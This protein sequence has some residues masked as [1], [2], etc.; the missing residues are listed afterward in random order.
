ME[1]IFS[2]LFLLGFWLYYKCVEESAIDYCNKYEVDWG[3]VNEDRTKN[4][5]SNSQIDRN[6]SLGKY[7]S[8][9][10]MTNAEIKAKQTAAWEDFK[11]RHPH[12]SWN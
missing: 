12:G 11:K 9:R 1:I 5:L 6:I 8:G 7:G 2:V 10:I 4:N 3:K